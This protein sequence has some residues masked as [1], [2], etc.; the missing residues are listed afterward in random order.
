MEDYGKVSG[1]KNMNFCGENK[2]G[3]LYRILITINKI[4][5]N[6]HTLHIEFVHT[7]W[8]SKRVR[9]CQEPWSVKKGLSALAGIN[10]RFAND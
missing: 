4:S 10:E 7:E 8:R 3:N 2:I 1:E 6:K 5:V 9:S